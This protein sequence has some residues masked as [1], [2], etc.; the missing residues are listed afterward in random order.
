[1]YGF[2]YYKNISEKPY[3]EVNFNKKFGDDRVFFENQNIIV[4]IDGII[5]NKLDLLSACKIDSWKV[6]IT[7]LFSDDKYSFKKLRGSYSG[8]VYDKTTDVTIVF[9]DQLGSKFVYYSKIGN[10]FYAFSNVSELYEKLYSEGKRLTLNEVGIRMVIKHGG[11]FAGYTIC[12]EVRRI[13]PGCYIEINKD[14]SVIEHQYYLLNNTPDNSKTEDEWIE[15]VDKCYRRAIKLQYDKDCEYGYKH[16]ANLSGG[17]DCRMTNFVS[18]QMGYLHQLNVTFSQT[19]FFDETTAK[20][21]AH[22]LCNEWLFKSL[23]NGLW[24]Y[25]V[26]ECVRQK[27][28][29]RLYYAIAH[30]RSIF[31]YINEN[32]YGVI[33]S[34]TQ[35]EIFKGET[36]VDYGA[37]IKDISFEPSIKYSNQELQTIYYRY[38]GCV[39]INE[40]FSPLLELDFLETTLKIPI[41]LRK[42]GY[43]YKKWIITKYPDA[44]K[45]IWSTTGAR[46]SCK[47]NPKIRIG[48]HEAYF[49]Q[50]PDMIR[51]K[52][53][54]NGP[55]AMNPI[56]QYISQNKDL[57]TFL[58]SYYSYINKIEN[59]K[60]REFLNKQNK[61]GLSLIKTV[62]ILSAIKQFNFK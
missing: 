24:L 3:I 14:N 5:T 27:G 36:D 37:I 9:S 47:F 35:G 52:L 48:G 10:E 15:I 33:H 62:T 54:G 20:Q 25:D 23:D 44:D 1:M 42:N 26:D 12:N 28:G 43:I 53:K 61:S 19:G 18:H 13:Q 29:N 30:N 40:N 60:I 11:T 6:C 49:R 32:T 46:L 34:G 58:L 21:I 16:L 50:I 38:I 41:E 31:K 57:R 2:K 45:Y 8:F 59:S 22:D 56:P 39:E 51:Q 17:M 4:V 55:F 7:K